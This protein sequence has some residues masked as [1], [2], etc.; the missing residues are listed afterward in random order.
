MGLCKIC[1]HETQLM[2]SRFLFQSNKQKVN[3]REMSITRKLAAIVGSLRKESL[4]LMLSKA[5]VE[6]APQGMEFARIETGNLPLHNA[7]VNSS[8]PEAWIQFRK[9][10]SACDAVLF[11]TP[12]YSRFV[13]AVLKNAQDVGSRP[14]GKGLGDKKPA[15]VNSA[16]PGAI[17]GFGAN[18]H[19]QQSLV[20]LNAP[21]MAQPE[22]YA[23]GANTLFENNGL[24]IND[25]ARKFPIMFMHAL[26]DWISANCR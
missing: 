4:S 18:H 16:S 9:A 20:F 2:H 15:A 21:S 17:G 25:G 22:V 26:G 14:D 12:E 19:I 3:S 6:G 5:L 8:P 23:G 1:G 24:L 13:P 7:D 11:V 10:V